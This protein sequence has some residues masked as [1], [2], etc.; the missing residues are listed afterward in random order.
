MLY[1]VSGFAKVGGTGILRG[2]LQSD[3]RGMSEVELA[4]K[5]IH[6]KEFKRLDVFR[7]EFVPSVV[8]DAKGVARPYVQMFHSSEKEKA[9][10]G[11]LTKAILA[12]TTLDA[13]GPVTL[14]IF[15]RNTK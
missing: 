2:V 5:K 11:A 4:L 8:H 15:D 14:A 6:K 1:V 10:A 13:R 9:H 7:I 12:E 3:E